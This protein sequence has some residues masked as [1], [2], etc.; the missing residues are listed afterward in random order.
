MFE[1]VLSLGVFAVSPSSPTLGCSVHGGGPPCPLLFFPLVLCS[2]PPCEFFYIHFLASSLCLFPRMHSGTLALSPLLIIIVFIVVQTSA[3]S[4]RA[5]S[6]H[7]L[8]LGAFAEPTPPVL[9]C[10][11]PRMSFGYPQ[12]LTSNL[13]PLAFNLHL[14]VLCTAVIRRVSSPL[15]LTPST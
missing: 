7:W 13:S 2:Q 3:L 6:C 10:P 14:A 1:N 9:L 15:H 11:L 4:R 12:P 8:S 5:S